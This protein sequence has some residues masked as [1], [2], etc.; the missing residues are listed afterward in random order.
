[1]TIWSLIS[2]YIVSFRWVSLHIIGSAKIPHRRDCTFLM[3]RAV[4]PVVR[5]NGLD[6]RREVIRGILGCHTRLNCQRDRSV[7]QSVRRDALHPC[8]ACSSFERFADV[9]DWLSRL[10]GMLYYELCVAVLLPPFQ[11]SQKPRR[12][13]MWPTGLHGFDLFV[14][15]PP[16]GSILDVDPGSIISPIPSR[17][18]HRA[19]S[20]S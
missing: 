14:T 2:L 15:C 4:M 9:I 10:T 16:P 5:L 20:R 7:L 13:T 3:L 12:N 17:L 11:V 6:R 8:P 19:G 1:M 18:S